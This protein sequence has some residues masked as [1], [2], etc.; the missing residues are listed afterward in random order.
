MTKKIREKPYRMQC[1]PR[2]KQKTITS[3]LGHRQPC[4]SPTLVVFSRVAQKKPKKMREMQHCPP[5]PP[6]PRE[7][8]RVTD[9]C[10]SVA[11]LF[12]TVKFRGKRG[13]GVLRLHYCSLLK[14]S[15]LLHTSKVY[16]YQAVTCT[17]P[18]VCIQSTQSDM[19][20]Q[21]SAVSCRTRGTE[22][23]ITKKHPSSHH[24]SAPSQTLELYTRTRIGFFFFYP[25]LVRSSPAD[26]P[27]RVENV[28][29][30]KRHRERERER[31]R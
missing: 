17:V 13:G 26:C 9:L 14:S 21:H 5:A 20:G 24:S 8:L 18:V 16:L 27:F 12:R 28:V 4:R 25:V 7:V 29:I 31:E 1:F 23:D 6:S 2:E 22:K 19:T 10:L 3:F 30:T 15:A 11:L